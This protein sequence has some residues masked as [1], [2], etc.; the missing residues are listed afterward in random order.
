MRN[1][2]SPPDLLF[3]GKMVVFGGDFRKVFLVVARQA[4]T[5]L[6][7]NIATNGRTDTRW[8]G[9][10]LTKQIK[11]KEKKTQ[12]TKTMKTNETEWTRGST[13]TPPR[14]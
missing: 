4:F 9:E 2:V 1:T 6:L 10:P 13:T 12:K 7:Y 8:R 14:R 5:P 3:G 11:D